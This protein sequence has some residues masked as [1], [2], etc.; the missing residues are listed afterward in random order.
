MTNSTFSANTA[1]GNGSSGGAINNNGTLTVTG[2]TFSGNSAIGSSG[3]YGGAIVSFGTLTL[4]L[5]VVAGNSA[6]HR[7]DIQGTVT[8]DGGGNVVGK[9][10]GSSGLNATSDRLGT[11]AAPLN[12]LLGALAGNGGTVQTFALQSGSPAI[13]ISRLPRRSSPP[14]HAACAA[15]KGRSAT[16]AA[17]KRA[18]ALGA[19]TGNGQGAPRNTAFTNLLGLTVAGT[20]GDPVAGG[21]VTFTITPGSGGASAAFGAVGST[22]CTLSMSNTVALCPIGTGGMTVTPPLTANGALGTFT[23]IASTA[24]AANAVFTLAVN[25][26]LA[27][28][29]GPLQAAGPGVPYQQR[30]TATGGTNSYTYAFS[31]GSSLPTGLT[32]DP[33]TGTISGTTP[34]ATGSYTFT[35][36][37]TDSSGAQASHAY[38]ITIGIPKATPAAAPTGMVSATA[39]APAPLT[40]APGV[41]IGAGTPTPL[42]QPM[43][44]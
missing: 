40:H 39:P 23:V 22:G 17:T 16:R 26:P 7:P 35:L 28:P 1:S 3:S 27:L 13:D 43:R 41:G 36:V 9:T 44:R 20:M 18:L 5:V 19:L 30:V 2:S 15:R 6:P 21:Q 4:T 37:V 42:P 24:G 34:T 31:S 33:A 25:P 12:A 38:T 8:T 11:A 29:A 14:M 32:L 10:D